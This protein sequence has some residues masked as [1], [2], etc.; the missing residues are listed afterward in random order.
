LILF[1]DRG[2]DV[3]GLVQALALFFRLRIFYQMEPLHVL[4]GILPNTIKCDKEVYRAVVGVVYTSKYERAPFGSFKNWKAMLQSIV[5]FLKN[6]SLLDPL[7]HSEFA[8]A[9]GDDIGKYGNYLSEHLEELRR[10]LTDFTKSPCGPRVALLRWFTWNLRPLHSKR[11]C[12]TKKGIY[13]PPPF[14]ILQTPTT[15]THGE[16]YIFFCCFS[17]PGLCLP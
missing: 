14:A 13:P 15:H 4:S 5:W 10:V 6:Y 12:L 8:A 3:W 17:Y 11:N 7:L 1:G 9:I 16:H 2:P